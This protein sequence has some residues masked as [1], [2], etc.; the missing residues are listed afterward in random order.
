MFHVERTTYSGSNFNHT[1]TRTLH[2]QFP[3]PQ[4]FILLYFPLSFGDP[5]A[6]KAQGLK[7]E[8]G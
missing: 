3:C 7:R 5:Y 2:G 1:T 6:Y 8:A 4:K